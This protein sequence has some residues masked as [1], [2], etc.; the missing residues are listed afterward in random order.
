MLFA[1]GDDLSYGLNT[2]GPLC[3]WQCFSHCRPPK[4]KYPFFRGSFS[5]FQKQVGWGT[6]LGRSNLS[7]KRIFTSSAWICLARFHCQHQTWRWNG[8]EGSVN[9]YL[10]V[11]FF[12]SMFHE[13]NG[14]VFFFSLY[15]NWYKTIR[16]LEP[17]EGLLQYEYH[18][19][20]IY[21]Y[22]NI[23]Q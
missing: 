23:C 19:T 7:I 10:F 11:F 2:L 22:S 4:L 8:R 12:C 13:K 20:H 14:I 15:T 21:K 16:Y 9:I 6:R 5:H 17:T 18:P 1:M 3:L